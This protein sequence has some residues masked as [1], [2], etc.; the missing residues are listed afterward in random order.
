LAGLGL[1][2]FFENEK[3]RSVLFKDIW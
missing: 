2:F 3:E 1:F